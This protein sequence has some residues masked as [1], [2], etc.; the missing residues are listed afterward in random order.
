VKR[1][2]HYLRV[3]INH[4]KKTKFLV[5]HLLAESRLSPLF[6]I[7]RERYVMRFYPT[8]LS[9]SCWVYADERRSHERLF[10][11]FLRPGDVMADVGAN[12]GTHTLEAASLVGPGGRVYAME[13]HPRTHRFLAANVR[14]NQF[15]NVVTFN[16][17]VGCES[18][19]ITF[20][21]SHYDDMNRVDEQGGLPKFPTRAI[22]SGLP[23]EKKL[24]IEVPMRRLDDLLS[25]EA[26]PIRLLKIDVEGYEKFVLAGASDTLAKTKA[27][28]IEM[29]PENFQ[30]YG[31]GNE[32]VA[33]ILSRHGFTLYDIDDAGRLVKI[34]SKALPHKSADLLALR[35]ASPFH[36]GWVGASRS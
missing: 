23:L 33:E 2:T 3:L 5:A 19:S 9:R 11:A 22:A 25:G 29:M 36:E 14:L 4:R 8:A 35:D 20:T 7:R 24:G 6:L 32:D 18:D 28:F 15:D 1:P 17:A 34:P 31:Y 26:R 13:A 12:I 21:D 10:R 27:I 30:V 16:T